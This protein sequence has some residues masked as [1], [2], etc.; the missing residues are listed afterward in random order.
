VREAAEAH[1][2]RATVESSAKGARFTLTL[3]ASA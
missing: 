2:G 3:P 1:G